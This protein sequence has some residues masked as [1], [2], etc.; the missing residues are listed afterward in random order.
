MLKLSKRHGS[1]FWTARGTYL[2]VKVDR[3]TGASDKGEAQAIL[4]KIQNEIFER[5]SGRVPEKAG[6][7]FAQAIISYVKL[8]GERRFLEPLLKYF[9]DVP[10]DTIDQTAINAAAIALYPNGSSSTRNRQVYGPVSAILKSNGISTKVHRLEPP[11]G[12][13]RSIT[14]EEAARL[15]ESCAPHLRPL[16]MFLLF[17]G[18]RAGEALWLQWRDVGL[19]RSHVSFQ[20]TK[21]GKPRGVPLHS[22]LVA[23]LANLSHRDGYVFLKPDGQ[24][25]SLP[26]GDADRSAGSRIKTGFQAAVRRAGLKDFRVH[27][28]RHTW[29]TWFYQEHRDLLKLQQ[30]GGWQTLALVKRYAH[31]NSET[32]LESINAMPSLQNWAESGQKIPQAR[33]TI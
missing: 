29:A 25:Y 28:L 2:G 6:P 33:K 14:H 7:G 8:G 3:S 13:V 12:V 17:T 31:V 18:A 5:A 24:P 22:S 1:K 32:Y 16:I 21:N 26:R 30:L 10:I 23:E 27:D 11:E 15:V 4:A 9:G 19:S 20:K